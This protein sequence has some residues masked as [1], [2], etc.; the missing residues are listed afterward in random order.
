MPLMDLMLLFFHSLAH[1]CLLHRRLSP[2]KGH[3]D[4]FQCHC[5]PPIFSTLR[6]FSILCWCVLI[7]PLPSNP[8]TS[9]FI[10]V[11]TSCGK[12][13]LELHLLWVGAPLGCPRRERTNSGGFALL[14]L[15]EA[16][17]GG[18]EFGWGWGWGSLI[19]GA[20]CPANFS[21][22]PSWKSTCVERG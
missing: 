1:P 15:T 5:A 2:C 20:L 8:V 6:L 7:A 21:K 22:W 12:P 17:A 9:Q 11:R 4:L 16:R 18:G 3:P 10:T 19:C 14:E 13:F